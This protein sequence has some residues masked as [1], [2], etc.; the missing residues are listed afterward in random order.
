MV[1]VAAIGLNALLQALINNTFTVQ[2]E[3]QRAQYN[4]ERA[5]AILLLE[6]DMTSR[7]RL[8]M[9]RFQRYFLMLKSHT[10]SGAGSADSHVGSDLHEGQESPIKPYFYAELPRAGARPPRVRRAY[11]ALPD[12]SAEEGPGPSGAPG[13]PGGPDAQ[14]PEDKGPASTAV[15]MGAGEGGA[16]LSPLV[17]SRGGPGAFQLGQQPTGGKNLAHQLG[18]AAAGTPAPTSEGAG[19]ALGAAVG[20]P[21][22]MRTSDMIDELL[23]APILRDLL[24]KALRQAP[25]VLA[26]ANRAA[27]AQTPAPK[28]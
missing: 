19:A 16:P 5:R 15:A 2:F 8:T 9:S 4:L 20:T 18:A 26:A 7:E 21:G 25:E 11:K 6:F 17:S 23:A 22:R 28:Q 10:G 14:S 12:P 27:A 1:F 13:N 24:I 3:K